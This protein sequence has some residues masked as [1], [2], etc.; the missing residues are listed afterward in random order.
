[1]APNFPHHIRGT[2]LWIPALPLARLRLRGFHPLWRTIPGRFGSAGQAGDRS[3]TLHLPTVTC[4]D[5][6]WAPPLSLAVT[7]GIPFWFLFLPL[8]GCFRSGGSR[9]ALCAVR[10]RP[11]ARPTAGDPIR[12]SPDRR[13]HAA[14]RGL[15][16]L[17]TPF[18]GAQAELSTGW[19]SLA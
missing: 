13:L 5:S 2:V 4:R 3:I 18:L 8:L 15:S 7:R 19:R 14:T 12:A 17:A 1:M 10:S 9:T 11:L 6:V 16:Q